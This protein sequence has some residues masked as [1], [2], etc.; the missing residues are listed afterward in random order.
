MKIY[1]NG[2]DLTDKLA[3]NSVTWR[4][5]GAFR[6]ELTFRLE[7]Y[8]TDGVSVEFGMRAYIEDDY[9]QTAWAGIVTGVNGIYRN[10]SRGGITVRC[11]GYEAILSHRY[12]GDYS[13]LSTTTGAVA[14]TLFLIYLAT[15]SQ[16]SEG[17]LYNPDLFSNGIPLESYQVKGK[18]LARVFDELGAADGS[19]WWIKEDGTFFFLNG[20]NITEAAYCVDITNTESNRITDL[21]SL[22]ISK[23]ISDYRN[24][25]TVYGSN[26]IRSESSNRIMISNMARYGGSGR[27]EGASVNNM[28]STDGA[29]TTA[30]VNIL[31]AY[32]NEGIEATF[33]TNT[34]GFRLFDRV[35]INAPQFGLYGPTPFVIT[36]IT[37]SDRPT[38][39]RNLAFEY[40][41][42]AKISSEG[43]TMFRPTEYWTETLAKI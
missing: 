18:S 41:I 28:I 16:T 21:M 35:R 22:E 12:C 2:A 15:T 9:G 34:Y 25:Q 8:F 13:T 6:S 27:Y 31:R 43:E 3:A 26:G 14:R 7:T 29:A 39:D 19:K 4:R 36:E 32:S 24:V 5:Y 37:A 23:D 11:K 33:T 20:I 40:K 30:A 1:V 10:E 42:K 38:G 17:F